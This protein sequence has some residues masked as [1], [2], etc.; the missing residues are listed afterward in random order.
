MFSAYSKIVGLFSSRRIISFIPRIALIGVRISWLIFE[1]KLL[2]AL[3]AASAAN[4]ASLNLALESF[5]SLVTAFKKLAKRLESGG[6]GSCTVSSNCGFKISG[7]LQASP[8]LNAT[9]TN[10]VAS[11]PPRP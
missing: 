7:H 8:S 9:E 10:A 4:A 1:R 2:L 6:V 11:C 3:F 5:K